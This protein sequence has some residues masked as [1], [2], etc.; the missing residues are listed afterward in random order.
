MAGKIRIC[1]P[2]L[3]LLLT[4]SGLSASPAKDAAPPAASTTGGANSAADQVLQLKTE[5]NQLRRMSEAVKRT[6]RAALD[7]IGECT[8]P[9]EM[10]GEIDI[11]GQDVIPIMP[12]TSA[13]FANQYV[14]PRSKYVNLHMSQLSQM[15]P[16]LQEDLDKLEIPDSEKDFAGPSVTE[17]DGY[18]NDIRSHFKKLKSLTKDSDDYDRL[19]L[20]NESRGIDSSCKAIDSARKKLLH[21]DVK[22]EHKEEKVER[23]EEKK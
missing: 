9:I 13:G 17:I 3:A 11:I 20:V 6:R 21:E 5:Q 8:Q 4:A 22:T 10:M 18:M 12:A 7:L 16:I 2:V 14:A 23:S 1:V 15:I 19:A